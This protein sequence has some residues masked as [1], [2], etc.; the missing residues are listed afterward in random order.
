MP[1]L[2]ESLKKYLPG[3][4]FLLVAFAWW[5]GGDRVKDGLQKLITEP[6]AKILIQ[7]QK[8]HL[9]VVRIEVNPHADKAFEGVQVQVDL[10]GR[11]ADI[12]GE[13][14]AVDATRTPLTYAPSNDQGTKLVFNK[15][16]TSSAPI[17]LK[18]GESIEIRLHE[19]PASAVALVLLYSTNHERIASSDLNQRYR[20]PEA[21]WRAGLAILG[22]CGLY[23][24]WKLLWTLL[25]RLFFRQARKQLEED[26]DFL[27]KC[28]QG[29]AKALATF[30]TDLQPVVDAGTAEYLKAFSPVVRDNNRL[31]VIPQQIFERAETL[32]KFHRSLKG[33]V[34]RFVITFCLEFVEHEYNA[35]KNIAKKDLARI[36]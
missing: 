22:L 34:Q 29:D 11:P 36:R 28:W 20:L 30:A 15:A 1:E 7:D 25:V 23:F 4:L 6:P 12:N 33:E 19:E 2:P 21:A 35:L 16:S 27:H 24:V 8:D 18:Q 26:I 10:A 32:P 5:L 13:M 17:T 3:P 31:H 9:H 14:A